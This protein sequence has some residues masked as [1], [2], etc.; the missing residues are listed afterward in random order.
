MLFDAVI[1]DFGGVFT[2]SPLVLFE[3]YE[4]SRGLPLRFI[5]Q[6]IKSNHLENAW[7]CY[8]RGQIDLAEFDQL[9]AAESAALGERVPGRDVVELLSFSIRHDMVAALRRVKG[10]GIR[11]GCI[12]NNLPSIDWATMMSGSGDAHDVEAI[13][14]EFDAVLESSKIGLR[15]PDPAIYSLMCERLAVDP[16]RCIFMD[17]LG[18]NLKP[19]RNMG[20]TTIKVPLD[21]H[22]PAIEAMEKLLDSN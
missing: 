15:K 13:F 22:A 11:T 20:M 21:D 3:S 8:E 5:G 2:P 17:D 12:T 19:A 1:F 10:R 18:I 16:H 4:I 9:F 7:A 6:V 14:S